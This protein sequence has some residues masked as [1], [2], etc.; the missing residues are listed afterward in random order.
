MSKAQR[1]DFGQLVEERMALFLVPDARFD[2]DLS[3]FIPGFATAADA[4]DRLVENETFKRAARLFITPDNGLAPLREAAIRMGKTVI[5]PT[6]GLRRGFVQIDGEKIDPSLAKYASWLDG[7]DTFSKPVSLDELR[8]APAIDLIVT[9]ASAISAAGQRFGMGSQYLDL[10]YPLLAAVGSVDGKTP[11]FAI[12]HEAQYW[13]QVL[14]EM[15]TDVCVD[16]I[17]TPDRV[18][19]VTKLGERPTKIRWDLVNG[20]LPDEPYFASSRHLF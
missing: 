17:F 14:S 15:P 9:A 20:K 3:W 4:V 6:Y 8:N 19:T 7:L 13:P 2:M 16:L 18:L 1:L 12:A 5:M 10:E 11:I